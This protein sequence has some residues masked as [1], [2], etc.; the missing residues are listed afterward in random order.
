MEQTPK[1]TVLFDG[2]CNLCNG[3]VNFIIDRDSRDRFRFGS[4]QSE[5]AAELMEKHGIDASKTDSVVVID[6]R[7]AFTRSTA[8]LCI[9][10]NM[11][12]VWP[13]L[14][15]FRVIPAFIRDPI[16]DWVARNR[17]K[18]FGKKELCRIPTPEDASKFISG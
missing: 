13:V 5:I 3:F 14:Y 16:Y 7:V 18:W 9:A 17:Y 8:A 15:V 6:R 12:G 11:G 10:K 4:L 2:V 1:I